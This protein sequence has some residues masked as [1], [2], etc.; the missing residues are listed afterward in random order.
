[1]NKITYSF[2]LDK[3]RLN[4]KDETKIQCRI[5][6]NGTRISVSTNI[7]ISPKSWDT[8]KKKIKGKDDRTKLDNTKLEN[9]TIRIREIVLLSDKQKTILTT[10]RFKKLFFQEGEVEYTILELYDKYIERKILQGKET[11]TIRNIRQRKGYVATYL[12]EYCKVGDML[13]GEVRPKM[14][15]EIYLYLTAVRNPKVENNTAGR[16]PNELKAVF[17]FA[18][19]VDL[20]EKNI[21]ENCN[22]YQQKYEKDNQ[23]LTP[24]ELEKI[25]KFEFANNYLQ[26]V[27]DCFLFQCYTGVDYGDLQALNSKHFVKKEG[28]TR[29]WISKRREKTNKLFE[30]PIR[31]KALAI[32]EKYGGFDKIPIISNVNYNKYLKEV[33][34]IVGIDKSIHTHLGRKTFCNNGL[35][36]EGLDFED[37]A[38]MVGDKIDTISK[39]YANPSSVRVMRKTK[40]NWG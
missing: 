26:K 29:W 34:K 32:T 27:A 9:F 19:K 38:S 14:F 12:K 2:N 17:E 10:D 13:Y 1:M 8:K 20:I 11:G 5:V 40:E 33:A 28:D 4:T 24:I 30:V 37:L 39:H 21:F 23:F 36:Y 6:V 31:P 18:K 15:E 16:V 7:A 35:N 25:E 22:P 3:N